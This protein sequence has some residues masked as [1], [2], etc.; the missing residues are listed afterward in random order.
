MRYSQ[1]IGLLLLLVLFSSVPGES[2]AQSSPPQQISLSDGSFLSPPLSFFNEPSLGLFRPAIGRMQFAGSNTICNGCF[3]GETMFSIR[4]VRGDTTGYWFRITHTDDGIIAPHLQVERN[5]GVHVTHFLQVSN[6]FWI[7]PP[8]WAQ[9]VYSDGTNQVGAMI[10][11][12][13]DLTGYQAAATF[14]SFG[15]PSYRTVTGVQPSL[16]QGYGSVVFSA[17]AGGGQLTGTKVFDIAD[18]GAM[19]IGSK[20]FASLPASPNGTMYYCP[21]CAFINPC[22]GGSTGA[23]AKR[24]NNAWRCD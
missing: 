4:G 24:L 17:G 18:D 7:G 8:H 14:V 11:A 15:L 13:A 5:G 6:D 1:A 12:D 16:F 10:S 23:F 21:D 2:S 3:N 22:V 9:S 19:Q 20:P